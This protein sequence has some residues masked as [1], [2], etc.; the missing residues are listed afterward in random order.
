[1]S[2]YTT[3]F[4]GLLTLEVY[5]FI[6][7]VYDGLISEIENLLY[8]LT[9]RFGHLKIWTTFEIQHFLLLT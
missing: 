4:V 6:D 1:M 5:G 9:L 3:V 8:W 7:F 2:K